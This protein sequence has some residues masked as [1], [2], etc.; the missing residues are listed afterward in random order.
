MLNRT[1]IEEANKHLQ[2]LYSRVSE[3]E[4]TVQEQQSALSA[5]DSFIQTKIKELSHQDL[6]I[7][8]LRNKLEER[9][10]EV[11]KNNE[12][13][14]I[15]QKE[16]LAKNAQLD[17][18]KQKCKALSDLMDLIPDLKAYCS[19]VEAVALIVNDIDDGYVRV[20]ASPS[21]SDEADNTDGGDI[22]NHSAGSGIHEVV[23]DESISVGEMARSFVQL[24]GTKKFSVTEDD[25]DESEIITVRNTSVKKEH[26]F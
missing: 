23:A 24:E 9:D 14:T 20:N 1:S 12:I 15:L 13:I 10:V 8:D 19:K 18:L 7:K 3:L 4:S 21:L 11:S 5:K 16:L 25:L 17:I 26:Y 22:G 2:A 6:A